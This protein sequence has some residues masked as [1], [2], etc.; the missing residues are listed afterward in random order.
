MK[1][2]LFLIA[3]IVSALTGKQSMAQWSD[4][5]SLNTIVSETEG[6]KW[7]VRSVLCPD[8][9]YYV[10]WIDGAMDWKL[11]IQRLDANGN[12]QWTHNGIQLLASPVSGGICLLSDALS[13]ALLIYLSE[14]EGA[15]RYKAQKISPFGD[16]LWRIEGIFISG[17]VLNMAASF[18]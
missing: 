8:E 18:Y 13:D 16:P 9:G 17:D 2:K 7:D 3:V 10:A 15:Y 11:C 4:N 14:E 5:P 1:I 12:E 6:P